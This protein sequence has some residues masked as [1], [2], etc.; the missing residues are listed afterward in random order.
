M[1]RRIQAAPPILSFAIFFILGVLLVLGSFIGQTNFVT[2]T[3][4][5]KEYGFLYE[6]NWAANYIVFIP[7]ALYFC[8][9]ALNAIY[10]TIVRISD[11]QMIVSEN[12]EPL[13]KEQLT[14]AWN[15]FA[16][17]A[18][19][20]WFLLTLVILIACGIEWWQACVTPAR[21]VGHQLPANNPP[22]PGWTLTPYLSGGRVA[23]VA[24][25]LFGAVAY[26][27]QGIV[28]AAF[29]LFISLVFAFACWIFRYTSDD[30]DAEL[31]PNPRSQDSRK[32][33][34]CFQLLIENL[35]LASV[36]LFFVFFMTR[37]QYIYIDSN[38]QSIMGFITGDIAKGFF[39]GISKLVKQAD[40][41]L[42]STGK[43]LTY[44]TVMVGAAATLTLVT[45]FLVPM[46]I[47]RQAAMRSRD[48]FLEWIDHQA[49][50]MLT[51]YGM[52]KA[53]AVESVK[54]MVFWPILYPKPMQ[55][56]L[57]VVV[58]AGCFVFYKLTLILGGMLLFAGIQQV[59]KAFSKT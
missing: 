36:T 12:G 22:I 17:Y 49:A 55:L 52:E 32:G 21:Y 29:L 16:S 25:Y 30:V 42:F 10:Q 34:E 38:S 47:V 13:Q 26:L 1:A 39:Q 7:L 54:S 40:V 2:D 31:Y 15:K 20:I 5:G 33:F 51:L 43:R 35:L 6:I 18:I 58:A 23:A 50:G 45:A 57:Y 46:T 27:A 24:V 11:S 19:Q 41:G 9:A 53:T 59:I 56:L 4:S 8:T 28:T 48:R 3:S 37:L 14:L 44:S